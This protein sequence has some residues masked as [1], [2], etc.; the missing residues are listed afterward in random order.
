MPSVT[1]RSPSASPP[2]PKRQKLGHEPTA[3]TDATL[4]PPLST[5]NVESDT[6]TEASS[7]PAPTLN[8]RDGVMLAPMVRSG[9]RTSIYLALDCQLLF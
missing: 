1:R 8:Y 4:T 3:E 5:V 6:Q 2:P 9:T 7:K